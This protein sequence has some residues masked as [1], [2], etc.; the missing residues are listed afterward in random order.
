VVFPASLLEN[1]RSK[2]K[3]ISGIELP[4][5]PKISSEPNSDSTSKPASTL[6]PERH[7]KGDGDLEA[8]KSVH[9]QTP[10]EQ[11]PKQEPKIQPSQMSQKSIKRHKIYYSKLQDYF[12]LGNANSVVKPPKP[13]ANFQPDWPIA[14]GSTALHLACAFGDIKIIREL[15]TMGA[16]LACQNIRGE[17]PL[18]RAV[19]FSNC[20]THQTTAAVV[21]ELIMTIGAVDF[22]QLTAVHHAVAIVQRYPSRDRGAKFYLNA[23]LRGTWEH[24]GLE[25]GQRILDAQDVNG[26]TA[27]HVAAKEIAQECY[28]ELEE[29]GA[30]SDIRN[31]DRLTPSQVKDE[32]ELGT[33]EIDIATTSPRPYYP[34]ARRSSS[35]AEE[36]SSLAVDD[37]DILFGIRRR[38]RFGA[39]DQEQLSW[40]EETTENVAS[41]FSL[42]PSSLLQPAPHISEWSD[43]TYGDKS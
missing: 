4:S 24:F 31:N 32:S 39:D 43:Y 21:K 29:L 1:G 8:F 14:D 27:L 9:I 42:S 3:S 5:R 6:S 34:H 37:D 23:L 13:P 7:S 2:T 11:S 38:I 36:H 41:P 33:T 40:L 16:N 15:K 10:T 28:A 25:Y 19:I 35:V 17:T 22:L 20:Y 30:R 12:G 18:M 26:N